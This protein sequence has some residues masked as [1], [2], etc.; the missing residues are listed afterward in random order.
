MP[1]FQGCLLAT[2]N[3]YLQISGAGER[4]AVSACPEDGLRFIVWI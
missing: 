3:N 4:I 1:F 2:V